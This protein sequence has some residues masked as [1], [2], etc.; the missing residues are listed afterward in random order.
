[1]EILT[2]LV[3]YGDIDDTCI[4]WRYSQFWCYMEILKILVLLG[5]ID[6]VGIT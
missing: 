5:D 2:I 1:M 4:I 3:L 6:N